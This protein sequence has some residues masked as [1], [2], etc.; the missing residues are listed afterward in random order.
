LSGDVVL[1]A[2]RRIWF[3]P[4]PPLNLE[5]A[6]WLVFGVLAADIWIRRAT[7]R[8]LVDRAPELWD[9]ISLLAVIRVIEPHPVLVETLLWT[10]W[11]G[12]A[13]T[14]LRLLPRTAGIAT[15]IAGLLLVLMANS[16]GKIDHNQQLVVIMAG[17]LAVAPIPS[18]SAGDSLRFRWP[19]QLC[20][21]AFGLM[22]LGASLSKLRDSGLDWVFT[23]NLRN[24]L[25]MENLL[26]RDPPL[27]DVALWLASDPV[28]WQSAA[29]GTILG[30]AA[31]IVAVLVRNPLIRIPAVIAGIGTI[32]GITLLMDLVGFPFIALGAIFIELGAL[33]RA[34]RTGDRFVLRLVLPSAGFIV[35]AAVT[36]VDRTQIV[37]LLP[38]LLFAA[39]AAFG[40]LRLSG[41]SSRTDAAA[42][43][44]PIA[45]QASSHR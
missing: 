42:P 38:L 2:W 3:S 12:V 35:V 40:L 13:A 32:V 44:E 25:A 24:I 21:A 22:L 10:V 26:L 5:A 6:R 31:L 37:P 9:P 20:R 17:V 45:D 33:V 8:G 1:R 41:P 27:Q 11:L 14:L 16:F 18:S 39:V 36:Y 34:R 30:E 28:L 43:E 4:E 19:V 7:Y 23:S 29:A 15:A